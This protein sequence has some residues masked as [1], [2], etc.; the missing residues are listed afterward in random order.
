LKTLEKLEA[1]ENGGKKEKKKEKISKIIEI[2]LKN[3][4]KFLKLMK[5]K[6]NN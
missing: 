5:I 2:K 6:S 1:R 3:K 4:L